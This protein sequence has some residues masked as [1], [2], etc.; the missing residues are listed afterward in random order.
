MI[1]IVTNFQIL[2]EFKKSRYF[3]VNLGLIATVEKNGKRAFNNQDKFSFSYNTNYNTTILGQGSVGDIKFY[4]DHFINEPIF[5]VYT[6]D[7]EEFIFDI[8]I[9]MIR[10]K[11]IEF[12]LG[13]ILKTVEEEYNKKVE[14][15]ELK[16]M[17]AK[18]IGNPENIFDNPG[19]VNY[20]DLKEYLKNKNKNRYN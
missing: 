20:E 8:D 11:G 17:E 1:N 14:N 15:D 10:E 18:P 2:Q 4:V 7:N 19:N 3:K 5:A 12:Y 6:D 9:K 13:F 16:K